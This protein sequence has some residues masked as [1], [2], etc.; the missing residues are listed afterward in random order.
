MAELEIMFANVLMIGLTILLGAIMLCATVAV[1]VLTVV[2]VK[3]NLPK[4]KEGK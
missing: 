1:I 3:E 4:N 2:A